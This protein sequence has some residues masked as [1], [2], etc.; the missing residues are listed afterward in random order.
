MFQSTRARGA[1]R[2]GGQRLR[3]TIWFQS[4]RAR[5]ARLLADQY[6]TD[7]G[8]FNPRARAARDSST[9][10][11]A[12]GRLYE[13]DSAKYPHALVLET[14]RMVVS[15]ADECNSNYLRRR[16]PPGQGMGTWGSRGP[17]QTMMTSGSTGGLTPWC[18]MSPRQ[19]EPR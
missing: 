10:S 1:R 3:R 16:E 6:R 15:T 18:S 13:L 14:T 2:P 4:T 11:S 8:R 7:R 12:K 9:I 5:G 17:H 19:F